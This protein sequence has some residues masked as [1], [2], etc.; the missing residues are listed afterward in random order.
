[1]R[2]ELGRGTTFDLYLPESTGV[3]ERAQ[4]SRAR[5]APCGLLLSDVQLPGLDGAR[6]AAGLRARRPTV[7]VLLVSGYTPKSGAFD[8]ISRGDYPFLQ[9]P[10]TPDGL[11]NR[12]REVL[13]GAASSSAAR[14][15][16]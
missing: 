3:D 11:A 8:A 12:V 15:S 9:K 4:E 2:S 14:V 13:D 5:L 6:L 10:Y 16:S 7:P 1:M